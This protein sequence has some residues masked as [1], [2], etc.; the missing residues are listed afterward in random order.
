MVDSI[1]KSH[2]RN[3]YPTD[4]AR[5]RPLSPRGMGGHRPPS[6]PERPMVSAQAR[7]PGARGDRE[8]PPSGDPAVL[9]DQ[10]AG[11]GRPAHVRPENPGD[12]RGPREGERD[13][14]QH[15][16]GGGRAVYEGDRTLLQRVRL[17]PDRVLAPAK[18][19]APPLPGSPA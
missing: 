17:F 10:A 15:R 18:N 3:R 9:A 19:T 16:D 8:A 1:E 4:L 6:D 13:P 2:E 12:G 5:R 7:Q 14:A 11:A